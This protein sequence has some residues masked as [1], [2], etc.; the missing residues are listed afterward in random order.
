MNTNE[1]IKIMEQ[2]EMTVSKANYLVQ[3]G[4][5]KLTLSEQKTIAYIVSL[6][7][8]NSSELEYTFDILEYC[9][10]CG[11]S[12]D[13][14]KNYN[15]IKNTLKKLSDRSFWLPIGD[16]DVLCR[17]LSKV[18]TNKRSGLATIKLDEDLVPFLIE[19]QKNFTNY[20]LLDVLPMTS[21]YSYHLY[22]ILKSYANLK[23]KIFE[24]DDLQELLDCNYKNY[25]DFNRFVLKIAEKEINDYTILNV[26]HEIAERGR[27]NKI[28]KV[29]FYIYTKGN[30]IKRIIN[31]KNHKILDSK[32]NILK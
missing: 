15:D 17:W 32:K 26:R 11:F 16:E 19:L 13:S 28:I 6:I 4:R 1:D 2:R 7:K 12:Y 30:N 14:G 23:V 9:K 31:T 22:E 8:P 20:Q 27:Y 24:I 5:F 3:K 25:A 29:K 18:R 21:K 10:I